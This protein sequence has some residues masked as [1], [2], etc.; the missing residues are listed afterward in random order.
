MQYLSERMDRYKLGHTT[1]Q[2]QV[3][4]PK[5]PALKIMSLNTNS[6]VSDNKHALLSTILK[7]HNPDILCVCE[8]KLDNTISDSAIFPSVSGYEIINR[9]DNKFGAGGVLI[10][11]KNTILASPVNDLDIGCEI[12]WARIEIANKNPLYIGSFYRTPSKDDPEII[13]QLHESVSK[14]TCKKD[15]VLLNVI[16]N[17]DV[18][19]PDIIWEDLTVNNNPNYSIQLNNTMLDFV[20]ANFL[21]RLI[22][23]PTRNDNILDLVLSTNPDIIYDLEIHPGMSDHNAITYQVNLSV[24]RQKK[25]DRY[26]YQYK[27]GNIENI[28]KDMED[29]C[30]IFESE[31]RREKSID[32]NWTLFKKTLLKSMEKNIPTK[33]I[34]SRWNLPWITPDIRRLRQQKKGAWDSGKHNRNSH[35]WKRYLALSKKVTDAIQEA[36]RKYFDDILNTSITDNPKKFYSYIKQKKSGQSN[37]PVIKRNTEILSE[38]KDKANVLND[39]YTPVFTREPHGQLP[40]IDG[41]PIPPMMDIKF[42]SP[43]VEKLLQNLNPNKAAGPD[44]LPTRMLKEVAKEIAPVLAFIFQQSYD[45]SQVP[46]D[47]QFANVTAVFKKG[48]KTNPANYRPVSLTC[49]LCKTME[50]IVF[51]QLMNHLDRKK[52]LRNFQHGFRRN[53]SCETQLLNTAEELSRRLDMRQ[54]IDLLILDFSKAF[55]TVPHRRLLHKIQHYGVEGL[56][57]KWIGSWLCQ[58]KQKVVLDG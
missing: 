1:R 8:S 46:S 49:I 21:T 53:H 25:P 14:L 29:L 55:D 7:E 27:K 45:T 5:V 58:R 28:K 51:S 16:I 11:V 32:E 36:H 44:L 57:N 39:P 6:L 43:G 10:A 22:N 30:T 26:V 3:R 33:K 47:W 9:K 18:N 38:P 48:E 4:R 15:G 23:T 52:D 20:N 2:N 13:N 41:T 54:T 19:T 31:N 40:D 35:A 24:K 17:G 37:I 42:T 56:T 34:T 50:H 12:V